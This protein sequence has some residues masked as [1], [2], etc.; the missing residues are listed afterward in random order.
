M[1]LKCTIIMVVFLI[2][3]SGCSE[4]KDS[5]SIENVSYLQNTGNKNIIVDDDAKIKSI[6]E[7]IWE[8]YIK[9]YGDAISLE[10]PPSD[11][12]LHLLYIDGMKNKSTNVRWYCASKAVEYGNHEKKQEIIYALSQ[13]LNDPDEVV[14]KA[15]KFSYSVLSFTFD[16]D[17]FIKSPD[18]K[19]VA[20]YNYHSAR[21]N[22]GKLWVYNGESKGVYLLKSFW[23][24]LGSI[25]WSPDGKKIAVSCGGRIS[26][27]IEFINSHSGET[28]GNGLF[29][30]ITNMK[31]KY[32]YKIGENSRPD[33][34]FTFLEWSPDSKKALLF[35]SFF[36]DDRISQKGAAIYNV[37]KQNFEILMPYGPSEV[38]YPPAERPK[39]FKW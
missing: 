35:Y 30:Y 39:N 18:G 21:F 10:S 29:E 32:G 4:K 12:D 33:P 5:D 23:G 2:F 6:S 7:R 26:C 3:L 38:D 20:F 9:K 25:D 13:L 34:W 16:G 8:D 27:D 22:D 31:S 15:A 1:K 37:D 11:P 36:D 19:N 24:S 28:Y 17:E 14:K